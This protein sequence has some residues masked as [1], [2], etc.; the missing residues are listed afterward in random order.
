[1]E[2]NPTNEVELVMSMQL[3][4]RCYEA[5][6]KMME[7]TENLDLSPDEAS[8]QYR[9]LAMMDVGPLVL[10]MMTIPA[11]VLAMRKHG[12]VDLPGKCPTSC[13]N[14]CSNEAWNQ[15]LKNPEKGEC[16]RE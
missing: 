14:S 16:T 12:T 9:E 13:E 3:Y 6:S 15:C 5:L 1:M 7:I 11:G 2:T 10:A 4:G 8:R